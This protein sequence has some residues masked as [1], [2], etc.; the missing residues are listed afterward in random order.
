MLTTDTLHHQLSHTLD[1][2]DIAGLGP[3]IRGKVRDSYVRG[4]RRILITSDRLSAFDRILTTIPFKGQ[5]LN[6]MALNWFE[7]TKHILENH[8]VT[9]PHP[10]V[11][12]AHQV[13]IIPVEIVVR[14]YIA[15]SAWRDYQAG[16][17][18]SGITLPAGLVKSQRLESAIITPSTKAAQGEHD[19]PISAE[20][21][22]RKGIVSE[23]LW[24]EIA[25]KALAL[26]AC[27]TEEAAKQGL[28]LVD[29]KYE[30]GLLRD[31]DGKAHLVLADEVHTP[32]SSRYW[33]SESYQ[34][35][36]ER[37]EDPE[38]LDKEFVRRWLI[39]QG[40]MGEGEA[41]IFSDEMRVEIARRY[42]DV[43]E[44]VTGQPFIAEA[45]PIAPG[46][47]EALQEYRLEQQS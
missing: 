21:L 7:K 2:I 24:L 3:K 22:L 14:G 4:N 25:E 47:E 20:E 46:I 27:G 41:P 1:S 5:V 34:E 23:S 42:I 19:Q 43:C 17:S 30:M 28:I 37:G 29:T 38:M 33:I 32:D 11:L 44:R 36:F 40:Y 13:E 26:F 35:R 12:I 45:G 6:C 18:V 16:R 15:G 8:I 31:A 39:E 10:N 9:T